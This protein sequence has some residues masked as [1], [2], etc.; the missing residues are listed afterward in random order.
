M[1][2]II[3]NTQRYIYINQSTH[4]F[5]KNAKGGPTNMHPLVAY[6]DFLREKLHKSNYG[7]LINFTVGQLFTCEIMDPF[8]DKN[9]FWDRLE[10]DFN[11]IDK[12]IPHL[13][14]RCLI[15]KPLMESK[16]HKR[17]FVLF[18]EEVSNPALE[19]N[20]HAIRSIF[21]NRDDIYVHITFRNHFRFPRSKFFSRFEIS[22][23]QPTNRLT[24]FE[25]NINYRDIHIDFHKTSYSLQEASKIASEILD[26]IQKLGD[27]HL[28]HFRKLKQSL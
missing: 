28:E 17:D 7:L 16:Q 11:L 5:C 8:S 1:C 18:E 23:I 9:E 25:I 20:T 12:L 3:R 24:L 26:K 6:I 22:L 15:M 19:V 13:L 27:K 4:H 10:K 2:L 14:L 21:P